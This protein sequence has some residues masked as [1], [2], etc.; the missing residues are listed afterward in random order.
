MVFLYPDS[1]LTLMDFPPIRYQ[2]TAV[3]CI[4]PINLRVCLSSAVTRQVV[5]IHSLTVWR[6]CVRE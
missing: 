5:I 1:V 6:Q 4:I 2:L 3:D